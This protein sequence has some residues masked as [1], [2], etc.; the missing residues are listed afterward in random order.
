MSFIS[1]MVQIIRIKKSPAPV[2]TND[3]ISHMVQIIL[4]K[5]VPTSN[6]AI[7]R[8]I[9]HMVQ[10]IHCLNHVRI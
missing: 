7:P 8:F 1:H 3:F 6:G 5:L 4:V 10:I 2:V 9:S